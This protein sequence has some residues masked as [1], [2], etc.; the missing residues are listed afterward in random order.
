MKD[1]GAYL[2]HWIAF[3]GT[4]PPKA[5]DFNTNLRSNRYLEETPAL[6]LAKD[7]LDLLI[8]GCSFSQSSAIE[9]IVEVKELCLG[10]AQGSLTR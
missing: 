8:N 9:P 2:S 4:T 6:M 10:F 1:T 5:L 3:L 7:L